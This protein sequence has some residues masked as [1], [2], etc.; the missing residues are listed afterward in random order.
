MID[1]WPIPPGFAVVGLKSLLSHRMMNV[2]K[3]INPI[4]VALG[5]VGLMA[6][7]TI[8]SGCSNKVPAECKKRLMRS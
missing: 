4:V 2:M 8:V 5:A 7:S 6:V 1:V 3:R